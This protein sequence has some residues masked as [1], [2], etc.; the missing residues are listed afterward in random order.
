MNAKQKEEILMLH[1]TLKQ[2]SHQLEE[3]IAELINEKQSNRLNKENI[4]K[5]QMKITDVRNR[6]TKI[7]NEKRKYKNDIVCL[8]DEIQ[9]KIKHWNEMLTA[10]YLNIENENEKRTLDE[11]Q[12]EQNEQITRNENKQ[13]EIDALTKA[14]TKRNLIIGEMEV[15]L[16]QLTEEIS[17]SAAVINRIVNNMAHREINFAEHLDKLQEQLERIVDKSMGSDVAHDKSNKKKFKQKAHRIQ[18]D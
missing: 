6:M 15:L 10:K 11:Y 1:V 16:T 9:K 17:E 7:E 2:K 12:M 4:G 14:I 8:G 18:K 3:T 13:I 5:L